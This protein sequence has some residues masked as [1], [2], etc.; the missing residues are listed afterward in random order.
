MKSSTI[1]IENENRN[2]NR[3]VAGQEM[4]NLEISFL[5]IS[6]IILASTFFWGI[7]GHWNLG[8]AKII[9]CILT[10]VMIFVPELKNWVFAIVSMIFFIVFVVFD[11][12]D[13]L[14]YVS[15]HVRANQPIGFFWPIICVDAVL[16]GFM[17]YLY[18]KLFKSTR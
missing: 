12:I 15:E 11:M 16:C 3:E 9:E 4:G 5:V 6:I 10:I 7:F 8:F 13:L 1:S 18:F 2:E 14:F 17:A